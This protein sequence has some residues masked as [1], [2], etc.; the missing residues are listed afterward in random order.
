MDILEKPA[1]RKVLGWLKYVLIVVFL[2]WGVAMIISAYQEGERYKVVQERAVTVTATISHF[3]EYEDADD[4]TEYRTFVSYT[5]N[6]QPY[7]AAYKSYGTRSKAASMIGT[8]VQLQINPDKPHEQVS[9]VK[10][11]SA[12]FYVFGSLFAA[13]SVACWCIPERVHYVMAFGW[14]RQYAE[15][16][17]RAK[18]RR[19][20]APWLFCGVFAG[21]LLGTWFV[22]EYLASLIIGLAFLVFG[23]FSFRSW[24]RNQ[25]L[26][27][28]GEYRFVRETLTEKSTSSDG[29]GGTNYYLHFSNG[30][31]TRRCLVNLARYNSAQEGET[32][33]AIYLD[34]SK[35]PILAYSSVTKT[36]S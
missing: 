1:R 13:L 22:H 24:H 16:D 32:Q 17:L 18:I 27:R 14:S 4:N 8:T 5:Y 26:V 23:V 6:N 21:C 12:V 20:M 29:D 15:A 31:N 36:V 34:N 7:S 11:N 9:E 19:Q 30:E 10:H 35:R 25:G 2:I 28:N 3:E 33:E